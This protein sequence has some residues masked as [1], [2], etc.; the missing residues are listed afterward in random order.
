MSLDLID[1][2]RLDLHP[3]V[4]GE[5]TRLFDGVPMS[6]RLDLSRAPRSATGSSGCTTAGTGRPAADVHIMLA[7]AIAPSHA[8]LGLGLRSNVVRSTSM[9]PN[10]GRYPYA[11]SKLSNA[12]QYM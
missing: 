3:Y 6:Y 12:L 9:R 1:E 5:G 10:V 7:R 2:L 11:H 4:A 8:A